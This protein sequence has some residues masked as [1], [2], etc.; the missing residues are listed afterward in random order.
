MFNSL[1]LGQDECGFFWLDLSRKGL[2][3]VN[4]VNK[5]ATYMEVYPEEDTNHPILLLVDSLSIQDDG[6][7]VQAECRIP[8]H[9]D[10]ENNSVKECID[11][12]LLFS[13]K[14]DEQSLV[15]RN[16]SC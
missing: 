6:D 2:F 10:L 8:K 12:T 1:H 11:A 3:K 15:I 4:Y 14:Y 9:V 7:T 5:E 13:M 16:P